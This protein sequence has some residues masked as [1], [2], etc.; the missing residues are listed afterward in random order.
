MTAP[1]WTPPDIEEYLTEV[2]AD[3]GADVSAKVWA[4]SSTT[5]VQHI[6]EVTAIQVD[7][8]ASSKERASDLAGMARS[9]VLGTVGQPWDA[10][11]VLKVD[12]VSG[13]LWLPDEDGAPRY[14]FRCR[15]H[16]RART[17]TP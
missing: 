4:Y 2:L 9:L 10:G 15:V 3:L 6:K 14:L 16:Y 12:S 1:T 5:E 7:V 17:A 13:P 11:I 8:R